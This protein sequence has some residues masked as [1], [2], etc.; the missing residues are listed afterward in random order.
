MKNNFF[1]FGSILLILMMMLNS[2]AAVSNN[3]DLLDECFD[4][5]SFDNSVSDKDNMN[6][7]SELVVSDKNT[8]GSNN[9][10]V[11]SYNKSYDGD[12]DSFKN[13]VD[14]V[15]DNKDYNDDKI[16]SL[17]ESNDAENTT[18]IALGSGAGNI[19]FDNGYSGYCEICK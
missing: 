19:S 5:T 17:K 10:D 14:E 18:V 7:S 6:F 1:K 4:N 15:S 3:I 13:S 11:E 12:V 16:K 2:V 8:S 9:R